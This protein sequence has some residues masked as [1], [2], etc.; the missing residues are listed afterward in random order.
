MFDLALVLCA[1][2]FLLLVG[3]AVYCR[4]L[5][6]RQRQ[7][8]QQQA[9]QDV[10][11]DQRLKEL[12]RRLDAYLAGSVGMGQELHQLSQ[13]V[14]PLP[15][16]LSQIE[17]RSPASVSFSQAARLVKLGASV[18]DIAQSCGL[19]RTEAELVSKLNQQ[20]PQ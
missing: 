14:A 10:V 2:L 16:K 7:L 11:R 3:L 19:T 9:E 13:L 1:V 20:R 17:Q 18:E 12:S 15:D 6:A 8:A 5:S 4:R